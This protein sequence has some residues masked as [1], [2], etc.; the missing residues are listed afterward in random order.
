MELV[1]EI[2]GDWFDRKLMS[3]AFID[4]EH[5][6]DQFHALVTVGLSLQVPSMVIIPRPPVPDAGGV[7]PTDFSEMEQQLG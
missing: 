7:A 2:A 1:G 5:L 4:I 6:I 3:G